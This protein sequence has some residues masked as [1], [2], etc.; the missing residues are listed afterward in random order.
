MWSQRWRNKGAGFR[1]QTT[2]G[3]EEG[4]RGVNERMYGTRRGPAFPLERVAVPF[5]FHRSAPYSS[6]GRR[7]IC[8][9][10]V[11]SREPFYLRAWRL[12]PETK[13]R[14]GIMM[15]VRPRCFICL[16]ERCS[17]RRDQRK[18]FVFDLGINPEKIE[19]VD[20]PF[21]KAP[22]S[23]NDNVGGILFMRH[24]DSKEKWEDLSFERQTYWR[25]RAANIQHTRSKTATLYKENKRVLCYSCEKCHCGL[26]ALRIGHLHEVPTYAIQCPTC[27][28]LI[29][30]S[31]EMWSE[32]RCIRCLKPDYRHLREKH[33]LQHLL[34]V[35][36]VRDICLIVIG[37][38]ICPK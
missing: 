18:L 27:S 1:T 10:Q 32:D 5:L 20:E 6:F 8:I 19:F 35:L 34:L 2:V 25:K 37:Y 31:C 24:R 13:R 38:K 22:S 7:S 11:I 33:D 28:V 26:L 21:H 4:G 15:S 16:Q 23:A 12:R 3:V 9:V 36:P 29:C 14:T 30:A 17:G